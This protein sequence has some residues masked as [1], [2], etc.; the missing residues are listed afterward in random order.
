[1]TLHGIDVSSHQGHVNWQ[2]VAGSGVTFA[3]TKATGGS[4]YVNPTFATNWHGIREAGLVRGAYHFAF[5]S[6]GDPYPGQG[7]EHEADYFLERVLP[8]GLVEGDMLA[9]DLEEGP[10]DVDLAD[11]ALRWLRR[12]ETRVGFPPLCYSGR[13]FTDPR[14]FGR[15]PVLAHFPLWLA[16]YVAEL[17]SPPAPW[18]MVAFWQKTDK[19]Q[20]AGVSTPCDLNELTQEAGALA[21]YGRPANLPDIDVPPTV[22]AGP[23]YDANYHSIS[24]NDDWSCAPTSM[25][26]SLW[27]YGRQPTEQWLES[28]MLSEGVV[29]TR[30]GLEDATGAGLAAWA[31]RHYGDAGYRGEHDPSVSFDEVATEAETRQHPICLGGRGWYHWSGVRGF[32]G[33][34]ILLANPAPGWKG[35]SQT[36]SREQW[37]YLGP[38]SM[39]RLV[40][41]SESASPAPIPPTRPD[42]PFA[43]YRSGIGSGLIEMMTA[44]GTLPAQR[45]STWLPLAASPA[46]VE[47]CYGQN[48]VLYTY[49]LTVGRGFRYPPAA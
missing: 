10:D 43:P 13:W 40:H 27:A 39:M 38:W 17:P 8:L 44:D 4:W 11:W 28:S 34:K 48:G 22:V 24:Q 3:W 47:T 33:A 31:S 14:G 42:D 19:A 32:D 2:Q 15:V 5:E 30:N 7:P 45:A 25:R 26:W 49:L 46:D 21:L 41:A 36:L 12:V 16:E 20:V 35:V 23:R 9:L 37:E 1:M 6:S 18:P 29:S